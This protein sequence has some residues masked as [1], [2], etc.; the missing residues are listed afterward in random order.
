MRSRRRWLIGGGVALLAALAI[1]SAVSWH[2]SNAVLVPD[3]D[4]PARQAE[5][6]KVSSERIVLGFHHMGLTEWHDLEGPIALSDEFAAALPDRVEYHRLP[7]AGHTESWNVDP[8]LYERRL[9]AFLGSLGS[10]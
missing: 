1:L 2:F 10:G 9:G 3:H 5:V 4:S 6:E 8:K 7:E